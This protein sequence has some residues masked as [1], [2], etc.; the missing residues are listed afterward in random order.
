ME[1]CV[2]CHERRPIGTKLAG[3]TP[4]AKV[5]AN[6]VIKFARKGICAMCKEPTESGVVHDECVNERKL[7]EAVPA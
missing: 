7:V 3:D 5:C 4:L 2:E 6:C 1:K